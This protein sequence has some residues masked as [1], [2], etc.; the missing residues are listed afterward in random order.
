[1]TRPT[2][3]DFHIDLRIAVLGA[4]E[5]MVVAVAMDATAVKAEPR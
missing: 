5:A 2:I 3:F 1:M 4:G